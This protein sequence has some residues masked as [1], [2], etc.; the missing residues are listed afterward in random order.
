MART[1]PA[2]SPT[3]AANGFHVYALDLLGYGRSP[4][5]DILYTISQQ[6]ALV[7]DFMQAVHL[8]QA[9]I[10]G[11]SMGGWV[12]LKLTVDHPDLIR[13]L[14][15]YDSAGIY[16]PA[17]Y[18][19]TL[20]TPT[21]LPGLLRLQHMLTPAPMH[22]PAFVA[23]A[24]L[25]RLGADAWVIDRSVES[26]TSGHD[27]LDFE[28]H[29]IAKPTLVVWGADDQLIPLATG[30]QIHHKIP[31]SSMLILEG[32]GHLAPQECSKPI[33]RGT[34]KFLEAPLPV[35]PIEQTVPGH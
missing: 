1:G 20:F 4:H 31:D 2:S 27:L 9:D 21:D 18:N 19:E 30:E 25:R 28:L 22:L 15:V 3:L 12:A 10:A 7:V 29:R 8:S 17:P 33:L 35:E 14:V 34:L 24:A 6:E 16:F 13:R 23:R 5:P 32:C 11:W 26:M